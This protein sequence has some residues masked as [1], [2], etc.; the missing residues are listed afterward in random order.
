MKKV[1]HRSGETD[2]EYFGAEADD[3]SGFGRSFGL[4]L[5]VGRGGQRAVRATGEH[6]SEGDE[7]SV[8]RHA[9]LPHRAG[10][11]N[12]F[13]VGESSAQRVWTR[14]DRGAC[15]Q[16]ALNRGEPQERRPH[17]C[18]NAGSAGADRSAVAGSGEASQRESAGG[19]NR[20]PGASGAG[21]GANGAG[22]HGERS[23][24][25]LWKATAR[26]QRAQYESGESR[27][28][29]SGTAT[30]VGTVAG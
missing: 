19:L 7:G 27:R 21:A 2:Q 22:E 20:D 3:R 28:A 25:V 26:M 16:R 14:S 24:K 17:G 1:R 5:R 30:R 10:D 13:S 4:G 23:G 12:A 9:A 8:R 11:G 18:A 15:A 6:D 29:E